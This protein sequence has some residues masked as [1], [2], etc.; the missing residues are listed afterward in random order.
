MKTVQTHEAIELFL[1]KK[2]GDYDDKESSSQKNTKAR[3]IQG[4][5]V[6][7]TYNREIVLGKARA[8]LLAN[9]QTSPA[10]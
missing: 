6:D 7:F 4:F 3:R 5:D 9:V 8:S 10:H 2:N 1:S